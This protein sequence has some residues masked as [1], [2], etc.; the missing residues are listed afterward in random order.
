[1]PS[2]RS[3]LTSLTGD[4]D[5]IE[6]AIRETSR[7]R[8]FLACYLERNR[9]SETKMLLGAISK[10][11]SAMQDGGN[12]VKDTAAIGTVATLREAMTQARRDMAHLPTADRDVTELPLPRFDFERLPAALAEEVQRIH[13]AA[14]SIHSTAYAMQAAGVYQDVAEQIAERADAIEQSCT[15]HE[16]ILART[17]RMASLLSEIE[18]ELMS[19]FDD[20]PD[21]MVQTGNGG[22]EIHG[23]TGTYRHDREIPDEVVEEISAA[24][25]DYADEGDY[26]GPSKA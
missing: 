20:E 5:A 17:A 23:F 11:E 4:Y 25:S 18:A 12:L 10:L 26:R 24:L 15:A 22:C 6:Q 7:G 2:S 14:E 3:H 13:E 1:M 19:A 16:T 21:A 8:W 9:S